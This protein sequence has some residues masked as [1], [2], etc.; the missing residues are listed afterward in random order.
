LIDQSL[1]LA[2]LPERGRIVLEIGDPGVREIVRGAYRIIYEI[3]PEQ[4]TVYVLRF[5][6]AARG[7]PSIDL[8]SEA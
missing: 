8:D 4:T 3:F 2:A 1:S 6:H 5:W 7:A